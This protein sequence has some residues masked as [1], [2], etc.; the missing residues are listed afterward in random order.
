MTN[1]QDILG[2]SG[3]SISRRRIE[4]VL[5]LR[6]GDAIRVL[7]TMHSLIDVGDNLK[8]LHASFADFL[9]DP[10]R[11]KEF[12]VDIGEARKT[13]GLAYIQEI[14][15]I[16]CTCFRCIMAG[17]FLISA[18]PL[19][20]RTWWPLSKLGGSNPIWHSSF[21]PSSI[22]RHL[23]SPV[24]LPKSWKLRILMVNMCH[25]YA[26][27]HGRGTPLRISCKGSARLLG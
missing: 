10:S 22:V 13:L 11:S 25:M 26:W 15:N 20:L 16:D 3:N 23:D 27:H 9:L 8:L 24:S 17:T 19:Q 7:N 14:C 6:D 18:L 1:E 5:G 12:T 21:Q 2:S 4:A